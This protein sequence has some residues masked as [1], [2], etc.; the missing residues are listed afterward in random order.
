MR[1]LLSIIVILLSFLVS[2]SCSLQTS[3]VTTTSEITTS[4]TSEISTTTTSSDL[5]LFSLKVDSFLTDFYT[6]P[7]WSYESAYHYYETGH[8]SDEGSWLTDKYSIDFSI[9]YAYRA[10]R[11][12]PRT[13]QWEFYPTYL[14][15]VY[16]DVNGYLADRLP[17]GLNVSFDRFLS[18]T[19]SR[20]SMITNLPFNIIEILDIL[21][22][23][24]IE[25]IDENHYRVLMTM[26][27]FKN[28]SEYVVLFENY[29]ENIS[30]DYTLEDILFDI[31]FEG[32]Q[33][34][35][36]AM[37]QYYN[38]SNQKNYDYSTTI[39]IK[40]IDEITRFEDMIA[41]NYICLP[42]DIRL[43]SSPLTAPTEFKIYL[44]KAE[45]SFLRVEFEPGHY[46]VSSDDNDSDFNHT[47][48]KIFD[49]NLV[50]LPAYGF[51][52]TSD[53]VYYIRFQSLYKNNFTDIIIESY[54]LP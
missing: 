28:F 41:K 22:N 39:Y 14:N 52:V 30:L 4:T 25:R 23:D 5:Q 48:I 46:R 10:I 49:E 26:E 32:N 8:A 44:Y 36:V 42:N 24:Q 29:L 35:I 40:H 18:E 38:K 1:R 33:L 15:E 6:F 51:E 7:T 27:P 13:H 9:P 21:E 31:Y 54:V 45:T 19:I 2:I 50:E 47:E 20:E 34:R 3:D 37:K 12:D 43:I 53:E 16:E 17:M 11:S